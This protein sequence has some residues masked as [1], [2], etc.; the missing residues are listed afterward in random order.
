M[1]LE[2]TPRNDKFHMP[3]EY[4][5]HRGCIMIWPVRPGSWPY[6]GREAKKVFTEVATAISES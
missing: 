3:A 4:D 5:S 6:E 2:T 1:K